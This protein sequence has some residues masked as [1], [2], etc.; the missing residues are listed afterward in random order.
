MA[1]GKMECKTCNWYKRS[2][3]GEE[4]KRGNS[5]C[6][7]LKEESLNGVMNHGEWGEHRWCVDTNVNELVKD[8]YVRPKKGQ[9]WNILTNVNELCDGDVKMM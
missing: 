4:Q 2:E 3:D 8:E 7:Y 5:V 1:D 6:I 9:T